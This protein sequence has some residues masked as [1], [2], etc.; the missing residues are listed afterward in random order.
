MTGHLAL[1]AAVA[2][3]NL[4]LGAA[5]LAK[6][7]RGKINRYFALFS[8]AVA[9]WTLSNGLALTYPEAQWGYLLARFAFA[10]A[11]IIP[12]AFFLFASVF[13]TSQPTPAAR[14]LSG[15]TIAGVASCLASFTPLLVRGTTLASGTLQVVYGP[16][17][18]P[19]AIYFISCLSVSLLLLSRKLLVLT[20][21]QRLQVR[22]LFVGV[23]AAALGATGTNLVI[24]LLVG[25]SRF[26]RY[27]PLFGLLMVAFVAHSII[28]HRLMNIR[29][30][31]R[32]GFVYLVAAAIAGAVFAVLIV[33][34]ADVAGGRSQ[35]VS[36]PIQV[37]VALLI[38]LAFQ[39][40][41]RRIQSSLDRYLYRE[42]YDYQRIIRDAS[43]TIGATLDLKSL[44]EY[45]CRVTI[46][47]LRPDF[48]AVFTRDAG[49][50]AFALATKTAFSENHDV[51]GQVP[52]ASSDPLPRF[53]VMSGR[54]LIKD[55]LG[56]AISGGDAE[57]AVKHL[58]ALGGEIALPMFSE[59]Q[60]IG[61]LVVG[62]KL[63]GDAYFVEDV[64]LLTTL[65]NQAAIA[66][67][68]AQ[69]YRQVVLV[70]EHIEN[71]LRTMDS[72]VITVDASGKVAI[73]N[74]TAEHLTGL[75]RS[76]LMS[77]SVD[78]LPHALG[79]Q[80]KATLADGLSRLQTET[81]LPSDAHPVLPIVSSTSALHGS[82][83]AIL[84]A[85]VV[86]SD[87]SKLK[88][89][90]SEKRRA[91]RLAAFGT[92]VS[93]IA[94]E[95]KNPLVAIKTFAELL[96]ERFTDTE[97]REDFSKVVINEIDRIDDL[98]A[99]LRGLAVPSPQAGGPIDI[100]ESI[101]DTL[102]LLRGQLEQARITVH[103]ELG[104]PVPH[105]A[106][107]AAQV[108]QLF[109][110][111]F[112]NA[113]EAMG[114]GGV[115]TVRVGRR[116]TPHG[117]WVVAEVSDTGSGIP[118]AIRTHIFDPFFTTKPRGSGLGLAICR[119]ITD[120]HR[121]ILRAESNRSVSGTTIM[122][123]FPASTAIPTVIEEQALLS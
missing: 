116:I 20:G 118:E 44:L 60:L 85:L 122:V 114:P 112:I 33:I 52:L 72:A 100:R 89:L 75:S 76:Q 28:R 58:S 7:P 81:T 69:L 38:A 120:A 62:P 79:N 66:V 37:G 34:L 123:E 98:V 93:G 63:S 15:F 121:G 51:P 30:V 47:T 56:R 32:R 9:A 73:C 80:L 4:A 8:F 90:E 40:L 96:P 78:G 113:I 109:L 91:E 23:L 119:G 64:E 39:P 86:F 42:T 24:P 17:H 22:Y 50:N 21:F 94:H 103:R 117:N 88:A 95:I 18:L 6:Q 74:S 3:A 19:F 10:S 111:L 53:L 16:L 97:F 83:G 57:S 104:D 105:V 12:I 102:V 13:P 101:I 31:V 110:N 5:V 68:N 106:I 48:V 29:L 25:T 84:G 70:N 54:A 46:Q 108:K 26:S 99:R 115:L 36:L 107:D 92:L 65:A 49:A 43:K 55:E 45:L 35:D 1:I 41:K 67:N 77:L 2:V 59:N 82:Q 27:G 71:I 11:S 87:L 14:L 61:L